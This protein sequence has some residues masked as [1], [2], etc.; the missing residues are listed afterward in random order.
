MTTSPAWGRQVRF[1]SVTVLKPA[2]TFDPSQRV[3]EGLQLQSGQP[4]RLEP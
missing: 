3:T 2:S 1:K 4:G